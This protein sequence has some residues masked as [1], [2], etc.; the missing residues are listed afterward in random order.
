MLDD[1]PR[2]GKTM[3]ASGMATILPPLSLVESLKR[4]GFILGGVA[5]QRPGPDRHATGPHA[6][7]YRLGPSLVGGG[8]YPRPGGEPAHHG[9]LFLDEL[10]EFQ[11]HILEMI[12]QPLEEGAATISRA[13]GTLRF[14]Q[15]YWR[16]AAMNPCP[17]GYYGTHIRRCKC[18][19][20]KIERYMG[21]V[22]GRRWIGSTFRQRRW[23]RFVSS[24]PKQLVCSCLRQVAARA[25]QAERFGTDRYDQRH[26]DA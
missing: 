9:I 19:P 17:C 22:S 8:A 21:K 25:R 23:W 15:L 18:T 1:R 24:A 20:T 4:R 16:I 10:A 5:A 14:N 13:K 3:L 11:R 6:T 7:P 2:G 26:N 12:R